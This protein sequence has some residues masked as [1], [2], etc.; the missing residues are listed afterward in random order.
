LPSA[1][2]THTFS[3]CASLGVTL[4]WFASRRCQCVHYTTSNVKMADEGISDG[5]FR[6]L[7]RNICGGT[8]KDTKY[9]RL[10]GVPAEIRTEHLRDT[11]REPHSTLTR[12]VAAF[13][14]N[15]SCSD[16][17]TIP[18]I[19]RRSCSYASRHE[20][21]RGSGGIVPPSMISALTGSGQLHSPSDLPPGKSL[22]V[23]I[24]RR[25]GGP[26]TL[27]GRYG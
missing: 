8:K 18:M 25:P 26:Q 11:S 14:N 4:L 1:P 23:S 9:L 13:R 5:L 27:T 12:S 3:L 15:S 17:V 6:V 20:D 16:K 10:T 2:C 22:P 21:V 19:R 7:Y 24:Y